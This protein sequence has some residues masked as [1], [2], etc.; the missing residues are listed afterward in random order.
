VRRSFRRLACS[1]LETS[2]QNFT[3]FSPLSSI[4]DSKVGTSRRKV[5]CSSGVEKPI[6]RSTPA[7]L[8]QDLLKITVSPQAGRRA[9]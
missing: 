7:R 8:Y 2:S 4:M 9:T 5:S 6:T 3:N 1:V